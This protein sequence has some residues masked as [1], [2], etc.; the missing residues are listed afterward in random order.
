MSHSIYE[1]ARAYTVELESADTEIEYELSA[2]PLA[3]RQ[4]V[5]NHVF[6]ATSPSVTDSIFVDGHSQRHHPGRTVVG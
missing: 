6:L 5:T 3:D 4:L 2:I 1:N